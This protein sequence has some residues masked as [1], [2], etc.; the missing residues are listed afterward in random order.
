[1]KKAFLALIAVGMLSAV[2]ANATIIWDYAGSIT[3]CPSNCTVNGGTVGDAVTGT[4][5]LN[6]GAPESGYGFDSP[7][8]IF[9]FDIALGGGGSLNLNSGSPDYLGFTTTTPIS[10]DPGGN[11][12]TGTIV[13][14]ISAIVLGVP[15]FLTIDLAGGALAIDALGVGFLPVVGIG[16][17]FIPQPPAPAPAP[18]TLALLGLGLAGL[19]WSRRKKA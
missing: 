19:G 18:A 7:T 14:E 10:T 8:D 15:A 2:N 6:M 9:N 13:A 4:I 16:G 1:M 5:G 17:S 11:F 3:D 12:L